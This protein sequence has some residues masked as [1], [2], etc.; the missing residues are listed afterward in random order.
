MQSHAATNHTMPRMANGIP[1]DT[2]G[3]PMP[4]PVPSGFTDRST[5]GAWA[6]WWRRHPNGTG[7]VPRVDIVERPLRRF[8]FTPPGGVRHPS[9]RHLNVLSLVNAGLMSE[10]DIAKQR[11]FTDEELRERMEALASYGIDGV[12]GC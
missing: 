1:V 11:A 12:I 5:P 4:I 7:P 8:D 6:E 3:Q 10:A 2:L 9:E